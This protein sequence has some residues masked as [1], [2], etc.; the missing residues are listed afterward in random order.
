[1]S[2][3]GERSIGSAGGACILGLIILWVA[4]VHYLYKYLATGI[5]VLIVCLIVGIVVRKRRCL[6]QKRFEQ[7][8]LHRAKD[9]NLNPRK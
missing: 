2:E 7:M 6:H 8:R 1:M 4:D 3:L 5:S 9:H